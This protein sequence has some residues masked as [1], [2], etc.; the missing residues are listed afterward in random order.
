MSDCNHLIILSIED[1]RVILGMIDGSTC[2]LEI[3][4]VE[5]R[6]GGNWTFTVESGIGE[7]RTFSEYSHNVNVVDNGK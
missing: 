1:G 3:K 7:T 6:D 4:L 2:K 5:L